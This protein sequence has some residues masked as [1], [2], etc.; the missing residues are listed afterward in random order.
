[1]HKLYLE[2]AVVKFSLLFLD[3]FSNDNWDIYLI[4]IL[5]IIQLCEGHAS[6]SGEINGCF[7]FSLASFSLLDRGQV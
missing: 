6:I 3:S 5:V 4:K 1:M 2:A 7:C